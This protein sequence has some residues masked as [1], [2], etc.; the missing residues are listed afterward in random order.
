MSHWI[1][2]IPM[3]K[4]AQNQ[5]TVFRHQGKQIALFLSEQGILACN[6]RCP[7]EGY[8][9]SEGELDERCVLTCHWHNWKFDLHTGDNLYGGDRLR[10]YPVEIR[11]GDIWLDVSDPPFATRCRELRSRSAASH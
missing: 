6:N 9:L 5:K 4:L 10:I 7:H 2:A 8:P 11:D 3:D 1:K